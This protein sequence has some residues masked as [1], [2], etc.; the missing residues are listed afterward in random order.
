MEDSDSREETAT[1]PQPITKFSRRRAVA[2]TASANMSHLLQ[3]ESRTADNGSDSDYDSD[4]DS[5]SDGNRD[6]NREDDRRRGRG[7][8]DPRQ[9]LQRDREQSRAERAKN[10]PR[11]GRLTRS[12][13]RIQRLHSSPT[14]SLA[15]KRAPTRTS[16]AEAE[17][18]KVI[19]LLCCAVMS[20]SSLQL[21]TSHS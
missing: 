10:T 6:G 4:R 5:P 15:M 19:F 16:E 9:Q 12:Q 18:T 7:R 13:E 11:N 17:D 20:T 1:A 2:R 21:R 3:E 14:A 8:V